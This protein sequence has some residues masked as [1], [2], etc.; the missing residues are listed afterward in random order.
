MHLYSGRPIE[1]EWMAL[2]WAENL[3]EAKK[4]LAAD[5]MYLGDCE[6]IDI[7]F[8]LVRC[9]HKLVKPTLPGLVDGH[10][11]C[12]F[13]ET[14]FPRNHVMHSDELCGDCAVSST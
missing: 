1:E 13:C 2:A 14:I 3:P 5:V 7:R 10:Q 9:A 8:N 4:I 11:W 6:Y 12:H